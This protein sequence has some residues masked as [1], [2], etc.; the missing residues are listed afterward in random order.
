MVRGLHQWIKCLIMGAIVVFVIFACGSP[1]S[2]ITVRPPHQIT[3]ERDG[4]VS[5]FSTPSQTTTTVLIEPTLLHSETRSLN[6]D[7]Y[8]IAWKDRNLGYIAASRSGVPVTVPN[9]PSNG[10]SSLIASPRSVSLLDQGTAF[11]EIFTPD[12]NP[13]AN[14]NSC[15]Q[16]CGSSWSGPHPEADRGSCLRNG[17]L[18]AALSGSG[19]TV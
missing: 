10:G 3:S 7:N 17:D 11:P 15:S 5:V 2:P 8:W 4:S 1:D 19:P 16:D 18:F 14:S 12:G 9:Y 13:L 6:T